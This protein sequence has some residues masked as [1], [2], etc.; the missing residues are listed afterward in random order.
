[1]YH[2]KAKATFT[3]SFDITRPRSMPGT[4]METDVEGG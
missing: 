1:M 3:G 2:Q 4:L